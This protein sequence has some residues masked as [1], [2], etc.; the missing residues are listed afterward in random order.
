MTYQSWMSMYLGRGFP[1]A[2]NNS[3]LSPNF[4]LSLHVYS[5]SLKATRKDWLGGMP[6]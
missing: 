4:N 2:I 6:C 5:P 1:A 3:C